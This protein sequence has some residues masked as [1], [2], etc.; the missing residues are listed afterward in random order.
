MFKE[1]GGGNPLKR[2]CYF[3]HRCPFLIPQLFKEIEYVNAFDIANTTIN[4]VKGYDD[5][6][7]LWM[8]LTK[9][10]QSFQMLR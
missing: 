4:P 5:L 1:T 3:F 7:A 8:L 9:S 2:V 6:A 10:L